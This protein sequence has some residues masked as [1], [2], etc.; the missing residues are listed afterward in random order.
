MQADCD[1]VEIVVEQVGIGVERDL[2]GLVAEHALQ[3]KHIHPGRQTGNQ[4]SSNLANTQP[5]APL[6]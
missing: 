2:R 1:G 3:R 4:Q 5:R 6:T